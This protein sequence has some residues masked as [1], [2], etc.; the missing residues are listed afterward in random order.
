MHS[1]GN[2]SLIAM[3]VADFARVYS[4]EYWYGQKM[5]GASMDPAAACCS[6]IPELQNPLINQWGF[7]LHFV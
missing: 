4:N 3:T 6:N 5:L 7:H 1:L 2:A